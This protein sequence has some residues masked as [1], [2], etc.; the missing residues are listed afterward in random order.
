MNYTKQDII[1]SLIES[2][3]SR[4]DSVFFTTSLGLVGIPPK[5]V[6]TTEKLNKLFLDAIIDVI[7]DGNILIPTYSYTFGDSTTTD[8]KVFDVKT[9]RAEIG[10]FPNY[11]LSQPGFIRS[12]DPFVSVA[13]R[14][15]DCKKLFSGLSNSS[16]GDNSFFA[17]IV[18]DYSVKCCSIGLGPNWTPFIH[19]AD[20][21]A[22]T[23]YRY[24][25]VFHGDIKNGEKLQHVDWIYSV[26]CLIPEAAS[27]AHKIGR[28]AE[29]NHIWK[30]SRLGRAR[31]YTANCKEYFD[32]AIEQLKLDKW[33]FAKGPPV[34]VET[35]EKIRMN[36]T[37]RE[38][39]T[40]S[41]YN[42]T[43]YKTGDW[44]GK[45]LVPEKWVCH[46]AKLMD[47]DGN[48]LSITPKLYSMSI[49]KKV[50]LK[51]LKMHLSE[52][53]R[54][55]YDKRDWGFVFKGRLEQDYYRVIIKSDFGFGTIKVI[56][57]K[58][59]KYA[60]LA[61]SMIRIDTKV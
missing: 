60:F 24:D 52:E 10:P 36:N 6:D 61:N 3:I 7:D 33:A 8:P 31:I 58:D 22:K 40:F 18:E 38:K 11:V 27:S 23:P 34:D 42:V 35:A 17:R 26:P 49:D 56:D 1:Q 5:R 2:G 15:K 14:G 32:F 43:E 21:M 25:K 16:Y 57:K 53:V 55:L 4:G 50:S 39:N 45:W 51:E 48:I 20:W 54:I 37:D 19:Y 9:T 12:I 13:C 30:K 28:L 41:L 59:R 47:L 29:E 44:I 46:E